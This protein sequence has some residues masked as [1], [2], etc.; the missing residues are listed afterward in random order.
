M[1]YLL[2]CC[3]LGLGFFEYV[4]QN[5][6]WFSLTRV[7]D[8]KK[9]LIL[10][11]DR[12]GDMIVTTPIFR[13]LKNAYPKCSISV[14]ASEENKDVIKY[15]PYIDNIYV[16]YKNSLLKDFP[17]LLKLRRKKFDVCIELEHSVI[18]HA[19]FRLII[20]KHYRLPCNTI[21]KVKNIDNW[22]FLWH[23][24]YS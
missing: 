5:S 19:I 13:E 7:T 23:S 2:T 20:M 16:N 8:S 10:K 11:Y 17:K 24:I 18:P 14:L 3:K 1:N 6:I 21:N 22:I 4:E 9:V 12:I 15:N